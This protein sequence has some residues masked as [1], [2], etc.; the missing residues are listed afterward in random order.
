MASFT[1]ASI[2]NQGII[3]TRSATS[4]ARTNELTF[5]VLA[6]E[7]WVLAGQNVNR[8][9]LTVKNMSGAN[10][11]W[12]SYVSNFVAADPTIVASGGVAGITLVALGVAPT[13]PSTGGPFQLYKKAGVAGVY[14]VDTNW[15]A[16]NVT[17]VGYFLE[18]QQAAILD[19]LQFV[20]IGTNVVDPA[21]PV[22]IDEGSII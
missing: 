4:S 7:A 8:A 14:S 11:L 6:N 20:V 17:A 16:V 5:S 9:Y 15:V 1:Y 22:Y 19:D 2:P 21:L 13:Y 12:Y 18:P 3:K 10:R